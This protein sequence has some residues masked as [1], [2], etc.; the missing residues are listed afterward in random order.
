MK[1]DFGLNQIVKP[2]QVIKPLALIKAQTNLIQER[3]EN[4]RGA[5]QDL[6]E[7]LN[8]YEVRRK[9]LKDLRET[10]Q[11]KDVER[12]A[13]VVRPVRSPEQAL[14]PNR[15]ELTVSKK[16]LNIVSPSHARLN[17]AELYKQLKRYF[18]GYPTE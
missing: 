13:S 2:A 18:Y 6:S 8:R 9:L 10:E 7:R 12:T 16:G 17:E 14:D 4:L 11:T 5:Q 15:I 1:T 3:V